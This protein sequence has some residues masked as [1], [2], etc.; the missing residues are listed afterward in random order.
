MNGQQSR[1]ARLAGR[2]WPGA[3]QKAGNPHGIA[4]QSAP[5]HVRLVR[6]TLRN[7]R[8]AQPPPNMLS[9]TSEWTLGSAEDAALEAAAAALAVPSISPPT[10]P[11]SAAPIAAPIGPPTVPPTATPRPCRAHF[12]TPMISLLVNGCSLITAQ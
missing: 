5:S 8:S 2:C 9:N 1:N 4:G 3:T 6:R 11:P 10:A 12:I 7:H